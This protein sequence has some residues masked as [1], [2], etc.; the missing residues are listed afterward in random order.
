M[1]SPIPSEGTRRDEI[2]VVVIVA[3]V[4]HA[5]HEHAVRRV[6]KIHLAAVALDLDHID[7]LHA[8]TVQHIDLIDPPVGILA[9]REGSL[10][11]FGQL[12]EPDVRFGHRPCAVAVLEPCGAIRRDTRRTHAAPVEIRHGVVALHLPAHLLG[13]RI[14]RFESRQHGRGNPI[15]SASLRAAL[16][17]ASDG[18]QPNGRR[19]QHIPNDSFHF[20]FLFPIRLRFN[21]GNKCRNRF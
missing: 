4:G 20:H 2:P 11:R 19:T 16:L 12:V 15:R 7:D 1:K 13:A 17:F 6:V 5:L 18:K 8:V 3:R 10:N 14:E 21:F 9:L